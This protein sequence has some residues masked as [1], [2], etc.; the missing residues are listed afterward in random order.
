MTYC[1]G[2]EDFLFKQ[3]LSREIGI[4]SYLYMTERTL[5]FVSIRNLINIKFQ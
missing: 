5:N 2:L 3:I 4:F 1:M